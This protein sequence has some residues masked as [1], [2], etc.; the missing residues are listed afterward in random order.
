MSSA[1]PPIFGSQSYAAD[2]TGA[3]TEAEVPLPGWIFRQQWLAQDSLSSAH[4]YLVMMRV[5]VP[6][7]RGVRACF[8]CPDCIADCDVRAEIYDSCSELLGD[9]N[10]GLGGRAGVAAASD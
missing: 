9:N 2:P 8:R 3:V 1:S 5:A 4:D 7:A 6:A 10:K